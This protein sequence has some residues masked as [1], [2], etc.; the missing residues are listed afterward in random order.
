MSANQ[1]LVSRIFIIRSWIFCVLF[2]AACGKYAPPYAPEDLSPQAVRDLTVSAAPQGI[3]F[4]W[5]TP[6][7]DQRGEEL[8]FIDGYLIR[9]KLLEHDRDLLDPEVEF[10]DMAILEDRSL[11][12]RERLREEASASGKST[13]RVKVDSQIQRFKWLDSAVEAGKVYAYRVV[14]MNQDGVEGISDKLIRVEFRGDNSR[15]TM[16]PLS[17]AERDLF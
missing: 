9:R 13:R 4:E 12:E 11:L 3:S 7:D 5:T 14:P 1:V 16:I 15:I 17:T 10:E 2:L 8:R 6:S